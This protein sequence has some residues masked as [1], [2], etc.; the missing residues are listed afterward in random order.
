MNEERLIS[1][2]PKLAAVGD[3]VFSLF[4]IWW[5]LGVVSAWYVIVWFAIR[6]VWWVALVNFTYY[7]PYINRYKHLAAI[8]FGNV[9]ASSLIIFSDSSNLLIAKLIAVLVPAISFW[10]IPSRS[11]SLSVMEKPH[12]R[13]K[14]FMAVLGVYGIWLTLFAVSIFQ[15]IQSYQIVWALVGSAIIVS[16]LSVWEW[17]EYGEKLSN[18]LFL[19]AGILLLVLVETAGIVFLWPVGYFVGSFFM[20]WIWYL[21]WLL[22]RFNLTAA[23]IDW[24]KQKGFLISN[25][26]LMILFLAFAVRWN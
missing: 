5:F 23:G 8:M 26:I 22:F 20:T 6:I 11:D 17:I 21:S 18:K 7:P 9:G 2:H 24:Q 14:F 4:L 13:W 3:A 19:M 15:I 10:L 12:R 1:I 16:G 25:I